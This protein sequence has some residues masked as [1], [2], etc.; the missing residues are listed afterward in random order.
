MRRGGGRMAP[1]SALVIKK[2][3]RRS[4]F[5][6]LFS[7]QKN[8][9]KKRKKGKAAGFLKERS[10]SA[11]LSLSTRQH[12]PHHGRGAP[13]LLSW[14]LRL[15]RRPSRLP[16]SEQMRR[17]RK[18]GEREWRPPRQQSEESASSKPN[19]VCRRRLGLRHALSRRRG[20]VRLCCEPRDREIQVKRNRK[21]RER[22]N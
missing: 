7:R 22:S 16:G 13:S 12:G 14:P 11:S 2:I 15:R 10:A 6:F 20:R 21:R 19:P 8:T 5:F 4:R 1:P 18:Q 9:T 17:R 3:K